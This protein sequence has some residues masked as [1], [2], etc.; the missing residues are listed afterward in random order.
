[1]A[2]DWHPGEHWGLIVPTGGGKTTFAG[3]LARTRKYVLALDVKGG[4][5]T[6]RRLHWERMVKWPPTH[7]DRQ[8][9]ADGKPFRRVVGATGRA[10]VQRLKRYALCKTVLKSILEEGGW[11]VLATDLKILTHPKFGGLWDEVEELTLLAREAKVSIITDMQRVSGQP[12]ESTD[13]AT[14]LGIGYTRDVDA[15]N[16]LGEMMGRSR[17]EM[18]GAIAALGELPYGFLVVNRDPRSPI[19]ITRPEK[20]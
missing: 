7:Q 2:T 12:R 14:W 9:M 16:R 8:D 18:R 17:A 6:L 19:I 3:G 20:L 10:E 13:Q 1:M 15:V 5:A 11:T 4:D